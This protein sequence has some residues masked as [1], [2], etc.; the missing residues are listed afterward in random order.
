[1][2][3]HGGRYF[4]FVLNILV[5]DSTVSKTDSIQFLGID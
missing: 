2:F 3:V 1:M 4:D 5:K